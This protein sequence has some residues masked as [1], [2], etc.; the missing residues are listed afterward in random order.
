MLFRSR[1]LLERRANPGD[2]RSHLL[3]LTAAGQELY[4]AIAPKALD[5]ERRIFSS[6]DPQEVARFVA[7]LRRIDAVTIA[8]EEAR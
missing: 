6:F 1:G 7:M 5:F 8:L 3:S 4:A 2:R